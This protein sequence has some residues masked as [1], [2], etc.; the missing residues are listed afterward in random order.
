MGVRGTLALASM[1][2]RFLRLSFWMCLRTVMSV[3]TM[4][5]PKAAISANTPA[6]TAL[7]V[8]TYLGLPYLASCVTSCHRVGT[9]EGNYKPR[10]RAVSI[11]GHYALVSHTQV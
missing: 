10:C 2:D 1:A 5:R 3:D 7:N 11:D 4:R 8:I 9:I 6:F